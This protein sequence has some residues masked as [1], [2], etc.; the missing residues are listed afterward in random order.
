MHTLPVMTARPAPAVE[1]A[2]SAPA[3]AKS[4]LR[5]GARP[6]AA[7]IRP[8]LGRHHDPGD[9][10]LGEGTTP[11]I[12]AAKASDLEMMRILLDGGADPTLTQ[13]DFTNALLVAAAGTRPSAYAKRLSIGEAAELESVKLL[14]EHGVDVNTFNVDGQTALHYAAARGRDQ[15]VTYLARQGARLNTKNKNGL[16]ALDVALGRGRRAWDRQALPVRSKTAAL[17]EQLARDGGSAPVS[18]GPP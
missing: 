7:L 16:T 10:L 5:H 11:L 6:N 18:A 12:R 17:L 14:V 9:P 3:L 13:R 1:D 15:L 2:V 8:I 4:L